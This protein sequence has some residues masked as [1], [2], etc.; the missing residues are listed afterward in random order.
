M[1]SKF[2]DLGLE[3]DSFTSEIHVSVILIIKGLVV[4]VMYLPCKIYSNQGIFRE[5]LLTLLMDW[6]KIWISQNHFPFMMP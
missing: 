5:F 3:T 4:S 2:T 1:N 6:P